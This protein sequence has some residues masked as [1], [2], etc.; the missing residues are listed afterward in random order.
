M[1][2]RSEPTANHW[3]IYSRRLYANGRPFTPISDLNVCNQ[4]GWSQSDQN[5]QYT[6]TRS[7]TARC[8][9]VHE[10]REKDSKTI[11]Q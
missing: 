11:K 10:A 5:L 8:G 7:M 2:P 6:L 4:T 9:T 3:G 1:G